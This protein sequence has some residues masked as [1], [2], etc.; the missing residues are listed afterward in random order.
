M[1]RESRVEKTQRLRRFAGPCYVLESTIRSLDVPY[2]D[3]FHTQ[4]VWWAGPLGHAVGMKGKEAATQQQMRDASA[5]VAAGLQKAATAH[6]GGAAASASGGYPLPLSEYMRLV[7]TM[8]VTF[9]KS[10][11]LR[12]L[13]IDKSYAGAGR[14]YDTFRA[15]ATAYVRDVVIPQAVATRSSAA[16]SV[17]SGDGGLLASPSAASPSSFLTDGGASTASTVA[18]G[19]AG[20]AAG[21]FL[22]P[23]AA[24]AMSNPDL[25]IVQDA[26]LSSYPSPTAARSLGGE[27]LV[28][29]Y[30]QLYASHEGTLAQLRALRSQGSS[31]SANSTGL[32]DECVGASS[33]AASGFSGAQGQGQ[34]S[35]LP[36]SLTANNVLMVCNILVLLLAVYVVW[37][38]RHATAAGTQVCSA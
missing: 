37:T 3:Y 18:S 33:V 22:S 6:G 26:L 1:P 25:A 35:P 24:A 17:G 9:V 7:V 10:T 14:F 4:E 15:K 27:E 23:T 20:S 8:G 28:C 38:S 2:G 21:S 11:M 19:G 36:L 30:T 29:Q 16:A 13:I 32:G 12:S 5:L 31:S 34:R